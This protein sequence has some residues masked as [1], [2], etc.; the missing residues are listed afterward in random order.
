MPIFKAMF[1]AHQPRA[2]FYGRAVFVEVE[3]TEEAHAAAEAAAQARFAGARIHIYAIGE[4]TR[5]AWQA[6]EE[7]SLRLQRWMARN[8]AGIPNQRGD[9]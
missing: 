6:F 8:R 2:H 5:E 1:D 4:S 3:R 7:H 9:L